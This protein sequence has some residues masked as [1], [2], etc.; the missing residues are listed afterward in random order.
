MDQY[1]G[2]NNDTSEIEMFLRSSVKVKKTV[3]N[4]TLTNL[5]AE[6]GGYVGLL[7]GISVVN[8]TVIVDL[9]Y[10]WIIDT[11]LIE[12]STSPKD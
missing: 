6:I 11:S 8:I 5:Y 9:V 1:V 3:L 10:S 2:W 12:V 4:Y 7:L